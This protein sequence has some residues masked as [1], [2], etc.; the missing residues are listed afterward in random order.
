MSGLD[1]APVAG[2]LRALEREL[3]D[4][5]VLAGMGAGFSDGSVADDRTTLTQFAIFLRRGLWAV[6]PTDVDA[7]LAGLRRQGL[8]RSTVYGR[9]NTLARFYT[10]VITRYQQ[11]VQARTGW[12]VVQPVDEFNRPRR[13]HG[14][15][16]RVPPTAGEVAGLFDGWRAQAVSA[17][18]YLPAVRNYVVASLWRRAGLRIT[19]SVMLDVADW[20]PD[21]GG[22]GKL[23]VRF[24]KGSSGRGPKARLV[25]GIDGVEVLLAWWLAEIRPRFGDDLQAPGA[26][27]FPG[28]QR[29]PDGRPR[30]VSAERLRAALAQAVRAHLPAWAGRLT[31]HG[32]RH[33]CASSLYERGVDLKAIQEL[34]G[35]EWLATTTGYIHVRGEHIEQAWVR[36]NTRLADRLGAGTE[37]APGC[38]GN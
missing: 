12:V 1:A 6:Q 29:M 3:V 28:E 5:F 23:H 18:K 8:S 21:L 25:P 34:L 4:R 26:P 35:H 31:P 16:V 9:A 13:P 19:E 10:F 17:R 30:R 32:L 27:L 22:F 38:A 24:G 36:A 14:G 11:E 15:R 2:R 37:E 7:W 33:F 20:Y